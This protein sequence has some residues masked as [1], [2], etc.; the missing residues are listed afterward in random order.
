MGT[1]HHG[2][3]AGNTASAGGSAARQAL[4]LLLSGDAGHGALG[5]GGRQHLPRA[6]SRFHS[7]L[8][9]LLS[10]LFMLASLGFGLLLSAAIRV[11]FVAAQI[12]IIAGFLPAFF[13]SGLI[14]DLESTPWSDPVRKS[15]GAGSLFRRHQPQP[16]HGR[17]HLVGDAA[18]RPGAGRHGGVFHRHGLS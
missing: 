12:S 13:L 8:L 11:Q 4:A 17:R 7:V 16:V 5:G 14:F 9:L 2:G 15:C 6:V 18:Q 1:G 10:S 3:H